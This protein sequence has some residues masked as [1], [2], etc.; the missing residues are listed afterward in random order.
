[1]A[2]VELAHWHQAATEITDE[3]LRE[4][5]LAKLA[6]EAFNAEVAAT[7]ATIAPRPVRT[8]VVQ[9]IVAL[10]VLF[11]YL[12][13]RTE[14]LFGG[15]WRGTG[16]GGTSGPAA[17]AGSGRED[18][19]PVG[20]SL[21][22]T[23]EPDEKLEEGRRLYGSLHAVISGQAPSV[24][25][26]DSDYLNALWRYAHDRLLALPSHAAI[27]PGALAAATRCA[28][29]Q[30]RL[31]AA[32][33]LGDEQLRWWA[34][35]AC[36]DSSLDWREYVGAGASS[37]LAMH[38]LIATAAREDVSEAD[39]QALEET[40]MAIGA[41][42]TTLDSLVDEARDRRLGEAGYIRL[43]DGR[44]EIEER[45]VALIGEALAGAGALREGAH[46]AMTLAGIAAYYTTHP[47]AAGRENRAIRA[48]V[49]G[50]L[51]PAI[52]PALGVL[53]TWRAAKRAR[54]VLRARTQRWAEILRSASGEQRAGRR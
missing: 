36:E 44:G 43:Y 46:H 32:A 17:Q 34:Q 27:T 26:P 7:L 20:E 41:V 2:R 3:R 42:N 19:E 1:M 18:A 37:V 24:D 5:A 35:A 39:A 54:G 15:S 48:A 30:L 33:A 8:G 9:A 38:A 22:A 14:D 23:G 53:S 11:D 28:E 50:Q 25:G 12:D 51:A 49:R 40:Y 4:V 16:A 13:G 31:H 10:E 21:G 6:D 47:G 29:A 52:W 45:L